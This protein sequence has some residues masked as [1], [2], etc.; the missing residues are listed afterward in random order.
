ALLLLLRRADG[1]TDI[2]SAAAEIHRLRELQHE[3]EPT[4]L[5]GVGQSTPELAVS[6]LIAT[7]NFAR[8]VDLAAEFIALGTP[9]DALVQVER[10]S[11]NAS[12]LFRRVGAA[13]EAHLSDMTRA[14]TESLIRNSIWH[15]TRGLGQRI[16]LLVENLAEVGRQDPVLELWPSQR[17]ALAG[18]LL[19]P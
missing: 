4:F 10:H 12:Q 6:Q 5:E 13:F 18:G 14:G 16:R 1:W 11:E 19:D 3:H 9:G 15:P 17:Q 7:Y 8:V 2:K